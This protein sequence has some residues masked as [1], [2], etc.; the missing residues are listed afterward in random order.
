MSSPIRSNNAV[1]WTAVDG[2]SIDERNAPGRVKGKPQG[3]I[4]I[5]G[6]FQKG[7]VSTVTPIGST[8]EFV[9]TFGGYGSISGGY[10]GY[11]ALI[12]KKFG[13]LRIV[14]VTNS[15]HAAATVN[16]MDDA[17]TPAIVIALTATTKGVWGNSIS[18]KV[19]AA[20][21]EDADHFN[22]SL[23]YSETNSPSRTE[24]Y[25]DC[26]DKADIVARIN[27]KSQLCSAAAG[28]SAIRPVNIAATALASGSDGTFADSD[29]TGSVSSVVGLRKLEVSTDVNAVFCAE[30]SGST[31][32][33]ALLSH[34]NDGNVA[35][36]MAI[37]S[38]PSGNNRAAAVADVASFRG[39]RAIYGWPW[40]YAYSAENDANV[41][42]R[43]SVV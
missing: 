31:I 41:L 5:V 11:Q 30:K 38:G 3:V 36:R 2:L 20:T 32:N 12:E 22:F 26:V 15:T 19:E 18:Y 43:K 34:V 35:P 39:D 29:Y 7:P 37:M 42:D 13:G 21:D 16:V 10:N 28:A 23:I 24:L 6:E 14:R 1:D 17:G 40:I 9:D 4:A 25:K 27:A 33:G 8:K